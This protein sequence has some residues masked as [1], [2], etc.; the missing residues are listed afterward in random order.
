MIKGTTFLLGP[1]ALSLALHAGGITLMETL[2]GARQG[3]QRQESTGRTEPARMAFIEVKLV[4]LGATHGVDAA[5]STREALPEGVISLP[6]PYYFPPHELNLR[7]Q[8]AMPVPLEYPD[9]APL[10]PKNRVVLRLFINESGDVD[11]IKV[12]TADVPDELEQLARTAFAQAK[13]Q[14]GL[15][16][17]FPVKSQM[18][19]EI[20]FEGENTHPSPT[21]LLPS[22]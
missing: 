16:G 10:V 17:N 9:N 8:V 3:T 12:E 6:G 2:Y 18:L 7:P 13:F 4:N 22:R 20:T 5:P 14:P 11:L 15:R 19:V 21:A 1:L